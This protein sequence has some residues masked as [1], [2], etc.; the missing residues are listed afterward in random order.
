MART[1]STPRRAVSHYGIENIT[2]SADDHSQVLRCLSKASQRL[3]NLPKA[4]HDDRNPRFPLRVGPG[5]SSLWASQRC[6]LVKRC[7]GQRWLFMTPFITETALPVDPCSGCHRHAAA[8]RAL[9]LLLLYLQRQRQFMLSV[10]T[11]TSILF[12]ASK[13]PNRLP[14]VIILQHA[15]QVTF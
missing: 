14:F 5:Q 11:T 8:E 15:D 1:G 6:C 4:F 13:V 10:I 3:S 2:N 12:L 7:R 9:L